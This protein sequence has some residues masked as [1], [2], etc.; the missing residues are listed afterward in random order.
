MSGHEMRLRV[1]RSLKARMRSTIMPALALSPAKG[2]SGLP[3]A[4]KE[5]GAAASW[6]RKPTS[7]RFVVESCSTVSATGTL[8]QRRGHLRAIDKPALL[9]P[10]SDCPEILQRRFLHPRRR[11]WVPRGGFD[12]RE[13]SRAARR[14]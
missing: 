6:A 9:S 14:G 13:R 12:R 2:R 11:V 10:T 7:P 1:L 3:D 4:N 8:P 5:L